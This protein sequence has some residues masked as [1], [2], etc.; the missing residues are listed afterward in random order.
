MIN[1]GGTPGTAFNKSAATRFNNGQINAARATMPHNAAA[2]ASLRNQYSK[3]NSTGE[4][5]V[6]TRPNPNPLQ[7][8]EPQTPVQVPTG[9]PS[10]MGVQD[11]EFDPAVFM[12]EA[13]S[14]MVG[15]IRQEQLME[16]P[17]VKD[18]MTA[19]RFKNIM[20]SENPNYNPDP[21]SLFEQVVSRIGLGK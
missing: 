20:N 16:S 1:P 8:L 9:G 5:P 2:Q 12:E 15:Q 19:I 7:G 6:G 21:R 10:S 18:A 11:T 3:K 4:P 14:T 13:V 17:R